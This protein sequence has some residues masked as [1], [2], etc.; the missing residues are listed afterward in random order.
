[1]ADPRGFRT[2]S[3]GPLIPI[4][5]GSLWLTAAIWIGSVGF[6]WMHEVLWLVV[7]PIAFIGYAVLEEA[8]GSVWAKRE[9][10]ITWRN[11]IDTW[12]SGRP[13]R[14]YGGFMFGNPALSFVIFGVA[15]AVSSLY[16]HLLSG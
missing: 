14:G 11:V 1:M 15:S 8:R 16:S 2:Q 3:P 7:P 12:M 9:M 10:G 13:L 6:G 4:P 5:G